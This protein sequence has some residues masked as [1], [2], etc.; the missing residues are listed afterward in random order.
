MMKKRTILR[1]TLAT[2]LVAACLALNA[3]A[4]SQISGRVQIKTGVEVNKVETGRNVWVHLGAVNLKSVNAGGDLNV[5]SRVAVGGTVRAGKASVVNI[6]SVQLSD[7]TVQGPAH[8]DLSA[9]IDKGVTTEQGAD[10]MIGGV[11][12]TADENAGGYVNPTVGQ[13][14]VGNQTV[15]VLSP[16]LPENILPVKPHLETNPLQVSADGH[17]DKTSFDKLY[18]EGHV[19]PNEGGYDLTGECAWFAEQITRLPGVRKWTIG[20]LASEKAAKLKNHVNNG[21][22]YYKGQGKPQVGHT[23]IFDKSYS[24]WGHVA[25]I[26]EILPG[27]KARLTESNYPNK[28]KVSHERIVDLKALAIMGFLR[29]E[30]HNL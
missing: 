1:N 29:T 28:H 24:K 14:P 17:G 7:M 6:A 10:V 15:A 30:A 21:D 13:T 12:I 27:G 18:P 3:N 5:N 26:N 16:A 20:S 19:F 23:I 2:G 22:G 11:S 4:G 25:V 9:R 8:F